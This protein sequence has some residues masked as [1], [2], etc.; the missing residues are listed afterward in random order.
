L[1]K[2]NTESE[3]LIKQLTDD[4]SKKYAKLIFFKTKSLLKNLEN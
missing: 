2:L 4:K 3:K 1:E